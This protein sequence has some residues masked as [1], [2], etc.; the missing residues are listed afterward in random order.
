MQS[1]DKKWVSKINGKEEDPSLS[2]TQKAPNKLR[3]GLACERPQVVL[4]P[5]RHKTLQSPAPPKSL[6]HFHGL[7]QDVQPHQ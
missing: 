2:D 7:F 5:R 1:T 6:Q 4:K 3:N